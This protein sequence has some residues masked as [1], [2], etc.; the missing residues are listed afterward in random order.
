MGDGQQQLPE[1]ATVEPIVREALQPKAQAAAGS[2]AL[3]EGAKIVPIQRVQASTSSDA[4]SDSDHPENYGFTWGNMAHNV[5]EH[6]A[7]LGTGILRTGQDVLTNPDWIVGQG[8]TLN[9]KLND[10]NTTF[11]HLVGTPARQEEAKAREASK[12]G[13]NIEAAGHELA[14]YIPIIGPWAASLG[15][16]AGTGDIGGALAGGLTDIAAAK[17]VPKVAGK[18][19]S[20]AGEL[21]KVWRGLKTIG[22]NAS[23]V[24]PTVPAAAAPAPQEMP[25]VGQAPATPAPAAM[26]KVSSM[27][28]LQDLIASEGAGTPPL[29]PNVPL[30]DQL[31]TPPGEGLAPRTVRANVPL[32]Q[33]PEI[34][35]GR[36]TAP[37][38]LPT[39]PQEEV[40]RQMGAPP[41]QENVPLKNQWKPMNPEEAA[42]APPSK[43]ATLELKYPD[44]SMRQLVHALGEDAYEAT[45]GDAKLQQDLHQLNNQDMAQAM[46]NAG[47]DMGTRRITASKFRAPGDLSKQEAISYLLKEK[48]LTVPQIIELAKKA[49]AK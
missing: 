17:A 25:N 47:E 39:V 37:E 21:P 9:E 33:T 7:G 32:A 34:G 16:Q 43:Q 40:G 42:A 48:K 30:G 38:K 20:E 8:N 44:K 24:P 1:G 3:P 31:F 23:R 11:S 27:R 18:V 28:R 4:S 46:M 35:G 6:L 15:E 29:K 45:G 49:V 26:P 14:S 22:E 12:A 41:L 10:P 36:I 13:H 19:V 5:K 2:K